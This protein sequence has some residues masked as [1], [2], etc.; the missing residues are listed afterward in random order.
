ML[1]KY[2]PRD[3]FRRRMRAGEGELEEIG[4]RR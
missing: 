1:V 2:G 4:Q 3:P